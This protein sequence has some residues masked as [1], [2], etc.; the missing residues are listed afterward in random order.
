MRRGL[1]RMGR[2]NS[3]LILRLTTFKNRLY[4]VMLI[5]LVKKSVVDLADVFCCIIRKRH[6]AGESTQHTRACARQTP[7]GPPQQP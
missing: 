5:R 1:Q 7:A 2:W 3:C 4:Y 6:G